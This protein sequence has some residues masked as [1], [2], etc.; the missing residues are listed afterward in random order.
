MIIFTPTSITFLCRRRHT[1]LSK[2]T[3]NTARHNHPQSRPSGSG[4]ERAAAA[5][6]LRNNVMCQTRGSNIKTSPVLQL[7]F[8]IY[9][10]ITRL[11]EETQQQQNYVFLSQ[12]KQNKSGSNSRAG[13]LTDWLAGYVPRNHFSGVEFNHACC[14]ATV[15]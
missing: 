15:G 1:L 6:A 14:R 3:P 7:N 11:V 2:L 10:C 9:E 13:W 12:T 4:D 8:N 5:A